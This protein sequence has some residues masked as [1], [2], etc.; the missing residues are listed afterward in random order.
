MSC[1]LMTQDGPIIRL[2]L[3]RPQVRNAFNPELIAELKAQIGFLSQNKTV[4]VIILSG[5]GEC[6][7]AGADL[8]WMRTTA[9][10]SG[11]AHKADAREFAALL[12]EMDQLP[13][14][15]IAR[16]HGAAVGGGLG[17]VS[18]C[19]I[20]VASEETIFSLA[21]VKVGLIPAVISPFVIAR[22]GAGQAR[23]Y[24][25]T[26]ERFKA[27]Q[28]RRIGLIHEV[29]PTTELD[30]RVDAFAREILTAGPA[31]VHAAKELIRKISADP[32]ADHSR[33]TSRKIAE[34]RMSSEGQEG[35]GA[36]LGKRNPSWLS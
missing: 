22:I 35:M 16:V 10:A 33:H 19:D 9:G 5:E 36:F 28:A 12:R 11:K 17:L 14:P 26:G 32:S 23:R 4:R 1:L 8:D 15:V 29:F 3:N 2:K 18:V 31:A 21:E 20:A 13:V 7:S 34:L 24:F 25:L 6:F 27:D 30:A